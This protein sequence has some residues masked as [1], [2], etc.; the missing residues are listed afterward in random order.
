[1]YIFV[2]IPTH[3]TYSNLN[4]TGNLNVNQ[5]NPY[6]GICYYACMYN[7]LFAIIILVSRPPLLL[8]LY[9]CNDFETTVLKYRYL[10]QY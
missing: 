10:I 8:V 2:Y 6:V 4:E 1:M 9:K 5:K 3:K 7:I